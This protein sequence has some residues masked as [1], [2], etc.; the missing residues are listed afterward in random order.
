MAGVHRRTPVSASVVQ[1]TMTAPGF[2]EEWF[3]EHSQA[4]LAEL[5]RI[6]APLPGIIVEIGAWEGRSTV[7]MAKAAHPRIVHTC[8]TWRGTGHE[9]SAQLA[10]ER[11]VF[12]QWSV[13]VGAFTAGNVKAHRMSWREWVPTINEPVAMAFIDAEHSYA[14][15]ADNIKALLPLMAPGGIIC[16]DDA[17]HEPVAQA[18][19][20]VLGADVFQDATLWIWQMPGDTHQADMVRLRA[21]HPE[22]VPDTE[23]WR[24]LVG[25]VEPLWRQYVTTISPFDHAV[26]P[27]TAAILRHVALTCSPGNILD[28]GSGL[29]TAILAAA[30]PHAELVSMD[31]DPVW[32]ANTTGFDGVPKSQRV[33]MQLAAEPVGLFD[34]IFVDIANGTEREHWAHIGGEH[35]APGG[36]IIF[37][38][39]QCESHRDTFRQVAAEQGLTLYSLHSLTNDAIGRWSMLA[40]DDRTMPVEIPVCPLAAPSLAAEYNRLRVTPSD[41]YQHLPRMVELVQQTNAQ[42]VIELGTRT[43]VST[44]AWLHGLDATGG[45][46]TSIDID[47]KPAIGEHERWE[48]MQGDDMAADVFAACDMADIVFIDT[49]HHYLHTLAEL[50]LWSAKVRPGGWIVCHDT[51]LLAPEGMPADDPLFPVKRAIERF[52]A[53]RNLEWANVPECNGLGLIK[54]V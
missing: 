43:G 34:L 28:L 8:D 27:Q 40:V 32:L 26:S 21:A 36:V 44:V 41:I 20:D 7:S 47:A 1:A 22:M 38:D 17:H 42:H 23:T 35:L 16:G 5:V 48:F 15:V 18:V 13:N 2:T 54:V 14:E 30:A 45:R 19:L 24:A 4:V 12:A 52:C 25:A 49:S 46:L 39:A 33:H 37:D 31:T 3:G 6:T 51:E 53:E 50:R 29:S 9:I 11:D 10:A